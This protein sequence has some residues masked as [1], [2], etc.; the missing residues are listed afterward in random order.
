MRS[1]GVP[2]PFF[3]AQRGISDHLPPPT[4]VSSIERAHVLAT[5]KLSA[6]GE[7]RRHPS[8]ENLPRIGSSIM[9]PQAIAL[10]GCGS[11]GARPEAPVLTSL[12]LNPPHL[13]P[14]ASP[15]DRRGSSSACV[16]H[17]LEGLSPSLLS[18]QLSPSHLTFELQ[19]LYEVI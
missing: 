5:R 15:S 19:L 3:P 17:T 12:V 16:R 8:Q 14:P 18:H 7:G 4:K 13:T 2:S 10:R 9:P 1:Q 6:P 11:C